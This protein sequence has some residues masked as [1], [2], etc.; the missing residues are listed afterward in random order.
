MVRI[1]M[2][3]LVSSAQKSSLA[4]GNPTGKRAGSHHLTLKIAV[5]ICSTEWLGCEIMACGLTVVADFS[6]EPVDGWQC[7]TESR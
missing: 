6:Q 2:A 3:R 4:F 5:S 7:G 1:D